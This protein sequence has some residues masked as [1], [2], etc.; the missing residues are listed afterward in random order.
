MLAPSGSLN[1]TPNPV[2]TSMAGFESSLALFLPGE[3]FRGWGCGS[4]SQFCHRPCG[5]PVS[6]FCRVGD[7]MHGR[8]WRSLLGPSP[9]RHALLRNVPRLAARTEILPANCLAHGRR[10]FVEVTENSPP[11]AATYGRCLVKPTV[12]MPSAGAEYDPGR[13]AAVSPATKCTGDGQAAPLAGS[14][15]GGAEDRAQLRARTAIGYLLRWV[16]AG[17]HDSFL[18]Q[19]AGSRWGLC[20]AREAR[21]G[22]WQRAQ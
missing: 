1:S 15:T 5:D 22:V 12:T 3:G 7:P 6:R 10:Q 18:T 19:P 9:G 21:L 20:A 4:R 8:F 14:P 16:G 17:K 11:N 2:I 13:A